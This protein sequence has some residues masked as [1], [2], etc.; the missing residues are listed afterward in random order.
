MIV[1]GVCFSKS[2]QD[3][4]RSNF[5]VRNDDKYILPLAVQWNGT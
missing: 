2:I 3:S 4:K 5:S 1:F